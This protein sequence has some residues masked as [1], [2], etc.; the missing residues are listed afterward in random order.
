MYGTNYPEPDGADLDPFYDPATG[1]AVLADVEAFLARHIAF[2][3]EHARIAT[4]LWAAH[5]HAV[6]AFA[7][8]P[9]LALLSPEPG[10]G[11][12]RVQELLA[13]IV[14]NPMYTVGSSIAYLFRRVADPDTR[15]TILLDESDVLFG[16]RASR[17]HED[18]RGFVNTGH[19]AG[20]TYGRCETHGKTIVPVDYPAFAAVSLAGLDDLPATIMSRSI[21]VRMRRRAPGES[22]EDFRPRLHEAGGHELR[23][24][25]SEWIRANRQRLADAW[26]DMPD[27][28]TDR[29]AD[30]WEAPFAVADLAGG[31]WPDRARAAAVALVADFRRGESMG[32]R[33][34]ADLHRVFTAAGTDSLPTEALLSALN[35]LDESPWAD[36]RGKALDSRGL[37]AR[38]RKY[39][40]RSKTIRLGERTAKGYAAADLSDA[41]TRYLPPS[42]PEDSDTSVT[43][44]HS[45]DHCVAVTD[46]S[47]VPGIE[48]GSGATHGTA[49][50]EQSDEPPAEDLA[51]VI[52]DLGGK[53]PACT[54]F[55]CTCPP[56]EEPS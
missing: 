17:D 40:V 28:I 1:A 8:T 37:S 9:R 16:P 26:P 10:S 48:G 42:I 22:I 12:S 6:D 14:P 11:K 35:D 43:T 23:D 29:S 34:L 31:D 13:T 15:P 50:T 46:V 52:A 18:L 47:A 2:P 56:D 4:V 53:C 32:V 54:R 38:L 19:R 30:V 45:Q 36:L 21:V 41:W 7:S 55:I 27:G 5:T 39:D 49:G 3:S 33:L 20:S 44:A 25:L 24:R 51:E